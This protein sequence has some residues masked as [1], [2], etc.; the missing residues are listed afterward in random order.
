[1]KL[2]SAPGLA[3]AIGYDGMSYDRPPGTDHDLTRQH[4]L[5]GV[6]SKDM[7]AGPIA[8]RMHGGAGTIRFKGFKSSRDVNAFVGMSGALSEELTL[9]IEYDDM[10]NDHGQVNAAV[11][12]AWDVGLR[13]ELDFKSLFRGMDGHHRLL[14]ILYTF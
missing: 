10:L 11:G 5:Y 3:G 7:T 4:G 12:Y 14:K 8:V 13:I 9:G 1:M 6:M 2:I